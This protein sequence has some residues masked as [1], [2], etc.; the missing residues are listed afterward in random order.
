MTRSHQRAQEAEIRIE[1][2]EA[3]IEASSELVNDG[4]LAELEE[5]SC[6][7]LQGVAGCCNVMQRVVVLCSV[8]QRV[9][10]CVCLYT[11]CCVEL[12]DDGI[13]AEFQEVCRSVAE[14]CSV[15]QRVAACVAV[16][17]SVL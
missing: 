5:V 12:L 9:G 17:C 13:L 6:S 10:V 3:E 8:L 4:K 16:R 11:V 2:L 7:V 1:Q 14:C 15:L